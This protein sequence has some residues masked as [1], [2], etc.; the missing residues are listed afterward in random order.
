MKRSSG[1]LAVWSGF[2]V[3]NYLFLPNY[4]AVFFLIISF[5]IISYLALTILLVRNKVTIQ[6]RVPQKL[7]KNGPNEGYIYVKNN[8]PISLGHVV[9]W[10]EWTHKM[11][12]QKKKEK[13]VFSVSRYSEEKLP[14]EL[15]ARYCGSM[16]V[17][18]KQFRIYDAFALFY[19]E[20]KTMMR[21]TYNILPV[22]FL[23]TVHINAQGLTSS[24]NVLNDKSAN[25]GVEIADFKL[26]EYG[27]N[28]KNIHWK[29][30]SKM[31]EL[32][33]KQ[34]E[35]NMQEKILVFFSLQ[36]AQSSI[37]QY[38]SMLEAL[39]AVIQSFLKQEKTIEFVWLEKDEQCYSI[40]TETEFLACLTDLM[41]KESSTI[42][43]TQTFMQQYYS[44]YT[45]IICIVDAEVPVFPMENIR[46]I[47]YGETSGASLN[48]VLFTRDNMHRQLGELYL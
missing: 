42:I 36:E 7:V 43:N 33:I 21:E 11:N 22:G 41:N 8:T 20:L 25:E 10:I 35:Q 4:F 18:I 12:N 1:I 17:E 47:Q 23:S 13:L 31:D 40:H 9:C 32:I 16:Q 38:D 14:I 48:N 6:L 24:L 15:P 45:H 27:D 37:E 39:S 2:G 30:S 44:F 19:T 26:Y 28:I 46:F 5:C 34:M 3:L 29:L